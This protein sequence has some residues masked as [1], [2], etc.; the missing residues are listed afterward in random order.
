METFFFINFYSF[1]FLINS[2]LHCLQYN[3][4]VVTYTTYKKL[5]TY[6]TYDTNTYFI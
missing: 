4:N 3:I 5:I 1:I 2:Y 6:A